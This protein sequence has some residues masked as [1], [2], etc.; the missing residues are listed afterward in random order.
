M[1]VQITIGHCVSPTGTVGSTW[2]VAETH[3]RGDNPGERYYR[4]FFHSPFS[5]YMRGSYNP[6]TGELARNERTRQYSWV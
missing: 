5:L 2:S 1:P 6:V 3:Y 4:G